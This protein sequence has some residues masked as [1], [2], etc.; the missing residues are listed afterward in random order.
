MLDFLFARGQVLPFVR[1]PYERSELAVQDDH[2][3]AI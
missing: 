1:L 3:L 2:K